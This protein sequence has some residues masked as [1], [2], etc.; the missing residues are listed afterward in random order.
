MDGSSQLPASPQS[1]GKAASLEADRL[2]AFITLQALFW[3]GFLAIRAIAAARF[4]PNLFWSFM[5]PR[6]VSVLAYAVA[7][8]IIHFAVNR[9]APQNPTRR[10]LWTLGF[11]VLAAYPLY[12]IEEALARQFAP[13][14]PEA[15]FIDYLSQFGWVLLA[16]AGYKFALD[17]A[18]EV[19]LQSVM[20]ADA[21][22]SA[23][24]AEIKMLRYQ[25][26]P[27]FLFNSLNAISTLVLEGRNK[28]AE[29]MLLRLSRFLRH[30]IDTDPNQLA[31]L[32]D[33]AQ[34][35]RLYLEME[36]V[37]FGDKLQVLCSVPEALH[38][39]LAPSLLLQ[40]IVENAIKHG[41]AKARDGARIAIT[42][43][44]RDGRLVLVVENDGPPFVP[45]G[46]GGVG[47]RNT[48]DRLQAIYKD[49]AHVSVEPRA[50]GGLRVEF[51]LP[52]LR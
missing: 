40:P 9:L 3:L 26:N 44:E 50:E 30:T 43:F 41:V 49:D 32:G 13:H 47:L 33:E 46:P 27:H 1:R 19:R 20:L 7:T 12:A 45:T 21:Q 11:C 51:D 10:L 17:W 29:G 23:H 4:Y 15:Q 16:W 42:A 28:D 22:A 35:Q 38:D 6:A 37:R 34:V 39:A 18:Q 5:G 14:W 2:R 36:A 31:R 25:L 24:A 48:R 8:T 52:L